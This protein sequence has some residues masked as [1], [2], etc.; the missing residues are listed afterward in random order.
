MEIQQL[1]VEH[2]LTKTLAERD[3]MILGMHTEITNLQSQ[4]AERDK[5]IQA[6]GNDEGNPGAG[7]KQGKS[8]SGK[9]KT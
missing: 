2:M 6:L 5:K 8:G 9:G 3:E 7:N 4:L 1:A